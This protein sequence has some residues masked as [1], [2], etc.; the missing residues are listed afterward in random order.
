MAND[1]NLELE[2]I[3]IE[4][5][6]HPDSAVIWLH[7]LGASGDDFVPIVPELD[8]PADIHTRFIFPHAPMLPVTVNGG[9]VMPAWY[10]ILEMSIERKVDKAQLERSAAATLKL[11]E[12][13]IA[14]GIASERI[15]LAG[16]SQGGAVAYEAG[17]SCPHRL[18]G[19]M[20]LSTYFATQETIQLNPKN[21]DLPI[22]IYH[23]IYDPVVPETLGQQAC[24]KLRALGY[25]PEYKAYPMAHSVC[26][27]Q[28][29]EISQF[30]QRCLE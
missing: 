7:G 6:S 29:L 22:A 23:G 20:A 11:M 30:I 3:E 26:P 19:L 28:I 21:S 2:Y 12:A 18:A 27:A 5:G 16:F 15:I 9:M 14:K 10:D 1:Q 8:L 25:S 4:T 13:Q 17:L 24:E